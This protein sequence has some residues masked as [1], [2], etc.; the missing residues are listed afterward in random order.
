[1]S[2]FIRNLMGETRKRAI[3]SLMSHIER[4]VYPHLD[5]AAQQALR[6]RVL[7][8][9][10]SYHDVCLDVLRSS[11]SDGQVVNED[12]LAML[13]RMDANLR[14]LAGARRDPRKARD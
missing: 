11:V 8:S 3:G 4:E 1:M 5:P 7:A 13:A 2:Q 10:T 14:T 12:A 6:E 9:I